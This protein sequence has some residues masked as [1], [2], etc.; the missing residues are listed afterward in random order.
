MDTRS[1]SRDLGV[2]AVPTAAST[3]EGLRDLIS[4]VAD[5]IEGRVQT[6]AASHARA[7]PAMNR[8]RR[9]SGPWTSWCR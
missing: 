9:S 6:R 7:G 5:V 2:P 8:L 3:G 4:A 1:L